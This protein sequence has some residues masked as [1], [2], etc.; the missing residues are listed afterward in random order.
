MERVAKTNQAVMGVCP[1]RRLVLINDGVAVVIALIAIPKALEGELEV[2]G[3]AV[4]VPAADSFEDRTGDAEAWPRRHGRHVA[5]LAEMVLKTAIL[6]EED[7]A[8][9]GPDVLFHVGGGFVG[10]D[11]KG[12][13]VIAVVHLLEE[14]GSR[15]VIGVEV[16]EKLSLGIKL[17]NGLVAMGQRIGR[18]GVFWIGVGEDEDGRAGLF[19]DFGGI[20]FAVMGD[21]INRITVLRVIHV[22]ENRADG[23]ADDSGFVVGRNDDGYFVIG[24][25]LAP[26]TAR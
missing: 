13:G 14:V 5:G 15:E 3:G 23:R 4:A 22:L 25:S 20:V 10:A 7:D 8:F 12:S 9:L 6:G 26:M 11:D 17:Q 24:L 16:D 19:G 21:D 2:V 18:T 1:A